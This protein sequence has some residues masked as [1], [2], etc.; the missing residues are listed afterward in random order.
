MTHII[1]GFT[2]LAKY[3]RYKW[4]KISEEKKHKFKN[5][6]QTC[7]RYVFNAVHKP[8]R[9]KN[10]DNFEEQNLLVSETYG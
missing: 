9:T 7:E 5:N 4:K 10:N 6:I 2:Y 1:Q 8:I 3:V